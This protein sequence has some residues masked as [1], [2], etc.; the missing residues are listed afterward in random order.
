MFA[1]FFVSLSLD[2]V[3][4]KDLAMTDMRDLHL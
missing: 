3:Y 2:F 1:G 4:P